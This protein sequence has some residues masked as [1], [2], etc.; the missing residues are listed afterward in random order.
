MSAAAT[1]AICEE[2]IPARRERRPCAKPGGVS[3]GRLLT[4]THETVQAG[5]PA[6]CPMCGGAVE[7]HVLEGRCGDCGTRLI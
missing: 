5:S 2:Q 6:S 7:R 3:L 4:R 1:A